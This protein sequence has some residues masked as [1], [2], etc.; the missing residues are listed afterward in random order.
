M[1]TLPWEID[2]ESKS[3]L[4]DDLMEKVLGLSLDDST[5]TEPPDSNTVRLFA[6]FLVVQQLHRLL[7]SA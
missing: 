5:F 4:Q 6:F 2:D 7:W 1:T 3:I